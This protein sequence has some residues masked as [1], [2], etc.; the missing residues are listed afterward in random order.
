MRLEVD[1]E[2]RI[3]VP[4][5]LTPRRYTTIV[6][7]TLLRRE[8]EMVRRGPVYE[9]L[10]SSSEGGAHGW[11]D[12][13]GALVIAR[14]YEEAADFHEGRALAK[15]GGRYGYVDRSGVEVIPPVHLAASPFSRGRALVLTEARD[16]RILDRDGRVLVHVPG[17][18]DFGTFYV[19]EERIR[20]ARG[21][22][23][24][25]LD[26]DG[27]DAVPCVYD[28]AD[29]GF[30]SGRA[31]VRRGDRWGFV[32]RDGLEVVPCRYVAAENFLP[33]GHARVAREGGWG[34]IDLG[35]REVVPCRYLDVGRVSEGRVRVSRGFERRGDVTF[36]RTGYVDLEGNEVVPCVYEDG[37]DF[38]DG[39]ATVRLR[40]DDDS[41]RLLR[42]DRQGVVIEDPA[43]A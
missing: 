11:E 10:A 9:G 38:A 31:R 3:G 24:G 15:R 23:V 12:E 21:G 18:L 4:W 6:A 32:D 34:L 28:A 16:A 19:A 40:G 14:L 5:D 1:A 36:G 42:I 43:T 35:G 26:L 8:G 30:A 20:I 37:T 17:T 27:R 22:R 33:S 41:V 29:H 25:F 39:R 13:T 2:L 7:T